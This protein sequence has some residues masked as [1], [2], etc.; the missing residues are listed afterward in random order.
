MMKKKFDLKTSKVKGICFH[1]TRQNWIAIGLF[2]GELQIWDF[3]NGFKIAE[4]KEGEACVRSIDF[5][6]L[7]SLVAGGG[8][9]FIIRGYDYAESKKAFEL[10][11]HVDFIRSVQFHGELPWVLSCSDDQTIRLWN[12]QSKSQLSVITGHGHYVM[13]AR[14]HPS[15]DL[16]ASG[17]LDSTLRIWD[18]SKLKSKFSSSHGTV[19]MLSNDVEPSVVTEA[20]A[21]GINWVEFHPTEDMLVTCSDDK[22]IK[23][24]KFSPS[25]AYEQQTFHGHTNNV[26]SVVFT[27]DGKNLV[28]NSEDNHLRLW[29]L[30]GLSVA[31]MNFGDERQWALAVHPELPLV[32]SGGDKSLTILSLMAERIQYDVKGS[33]VAF[34]SMIDRTLKV[35]E[36]SSG[37]CVNLNFP[38][39]NLIEK[40]SSD[41]IK[42]QFLTLN[43]FST[44]TTSSGILSLK[45][46]GEKH[47]FV[48]NGI[49]G[50][51]FNGVPLKMKRGVFVSSEKMLVLSDNGHLKQY[52]VQG[53]TLLND[54]VLPYDVDDIFQG[55]LGKVFLRSK[56]RL[57]YYDVL[58]K[59]EIFSI[60]EED[61]KE[62]KKIVWNSV[63]NLFAVLTRFSIYIYDKRGKK[64][65][66]KREE[67][68]I[69]SA[70]W[71]PDGS[72][73]YNTHEHI[74]YILRDGEIGLVRSIDKIIFLAFCL[75]NKLIVFDVNENFEELE[76]DTSEI[77]FK[78]ALAKNSVDDIKRILKE[79]QFLGKS[80]ISFLLSKK[81]NSIA[82]QLTKDKETAFY[83]ALHSG[84]LQQAF[85]ISRELDQK[86]KFALLAEESMRAGNPS[87][88][89]V[90]LQ[91]SQNT[92]K[93]LSHYAIT[94]D[95]K[96]M[97]KLAFNDPIKRFNKTL[98]T[99]DVRERIKILSDAGQIALA[100]ATARTYNIKEYV[101]TLEKAYPELKDSIV[102]PEKASMFVPPK[103]IVGDHST[104][105]KIMDSWPTKEIIDEIRV[106][107]DDPSADEEEETEKES[108]FNVQSQTKLD[109]QVPR[110]STDVGSKVGGGYNKPS[111]HV[112]QSQ[113]NTIT[114]VNLGINVDPDEAED[115]WGVDNDFEYEEFDKEEEKHDESEA[116]KLPTKL[117]G[118]TGVFFEEEDIIERRIK[119]ASS[120]SWEH[121][122]IGNIETGLKL[123]RTQIGLK[124]TG[125]I[126]KLIIEFA[127]SAKLFSN[128]G[129]CPNSTFSD[130][131]VDE[132]GLQ[133][134]NKY[135]FGYFK[136]KYD[137]MMQAF[138]KA[139]I[140][141]ALDIGKQI[142]LP[143]IFA[144]IN[145][146]AEADALELFKRRLLN[147]S[148]ALRAKLAHD[149]EADLKRKIEL[150]FIMGLSNLEPAH[151][152][153]ILQIVINTFI[154]LENYCHAL[155][156]IR[157]FL[158][159][160]DEN[161]GITK[162][163]NITK[164]KKLLVVCEQ[165]GTNA[166]DVDFKEK[167]LYDETI[168]SRIDFEKL[169]F[170]SDESSGEKMVSCPF[171]DSAYE[172]SAKGQVCR[173]CE[174]SEIGYDAVK[175][176]ISESYG[177]GQK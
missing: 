135:S 145:S 76:L 85:E 50:G 77:E 130:Y 73:F 96:A 15:K 172:L 125:G 7:Q 84:N 46:N 87:L 41:R 121:F 107:G 28:S 94:G 157:R 156:M 3:R 143:L 106:V 32:A 126:R 63:K 149:K 141:D 58:A 159:T 75:S 59:T 168:V 173:F 21:K 112:G 86:E 118:Q 36:R 136:L 124:S 123:L 31:K 146:Q 98:F 26:S 37:V 163:D 78:N 67:A 72:F 45:Q 81:Y 97:K 52:R 91:L 40:E 165:K 34:Y 93:L 22:F 61:F 132:G 42:A 49:I 55:S 99:G 71:S 30:N 39:T 23:L 110:Q 120:L 105:V 27:K 82:L 100:Y 12:W 177:K 5:H 151:R 24:W 129:V 134:Y 64:R 137:Q 60:E 148:L 38:G 8:D 152:I 1:K 53:L 155:C 169:K 153:L 16:I 161:P 54:L 17:S 171:D 33:I 29:D 115:A 66:G 104:S 70:I 74:K 154:K 43:P 14:F 6:P 103:P 90:C 2:T 170:N 10:K 79:K 113:A 69:K 68:R 158:K 131:L 89:E 133:L 119:K 139:K 92:E 140:Q 144:K 80:M 174:T 150:C 56:E 167:F 83:L 138:T 13:C 47:T 166:I 51:A 108:Y 18:F 111:T 102:L 117:A 35:F 62:T 162:E 4:F 147:Y 19:Y 57:I 65:A 109:S 48:F 128:I 176:S 160:C 9:D 20:H 114:N 95:Q 127:A 101:N 175:F 88:A 122:A 25:G 164:M 142:L 11:G 116:V 44:G